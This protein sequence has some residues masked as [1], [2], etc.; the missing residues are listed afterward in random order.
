M[1]GR[2]EPDPTSAARVAA[3]LAAAEGGPSAW[4]KKAG[5]PKQTVAPWLR[6][7]NRIPRAGAERLEKALL[8]IGMTWDAFV[9]Y[10]AA[11]VGHEGDPAA[12]AVRVKI[13]RTIRTLTFGELTLVHAAIT[14]RLQQ[15]YERAASPDRE[16]LGR[17]LSISLGHRDYPVGPGVPDASVETRADAVVGERRPAEEDPGRSAGN[18][19]RAG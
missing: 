2:R 10:M 18:S 1:N 17:I 16:A 11:G 4:A 3:Y 15:L 12:A 6:E 9:E 19:R 13:I 5:I 14:E 8:S 7:E